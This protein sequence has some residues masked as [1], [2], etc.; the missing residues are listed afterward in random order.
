M[1]KWLGFTVF[2]GIVII[3]IIGVFAYFTLKSEQPPSISNAPYALQCFYEDENGLRV[4]TRIYYAESIEIVDGKAELNKY[5]SF[6][7]EKYHRHDNIKPVEPPF[8]I[9]RRLK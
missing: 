7:G 1:L 2:I 8:T 5:W 4:P 9:V 6:D 3:I